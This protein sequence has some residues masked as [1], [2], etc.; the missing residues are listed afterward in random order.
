MDLEA[1]CFVS[2]CTVCTMVKM[3][4]KTR[5]RVYIALP[6]L[7]WLVCNVG[8]CFLTSGEVIPVVKLPCWWGK[9]LCGLNFIFALVTRQ[10]MQSIKLFNRR[11]NTSPQHSVR[12]MLLNWLKAL[13]FCFWGLDTFFL[14]GLQGLLMCENKIFIYNCLPNAVPQTTVLGLTGFS[15]DWG[16]HWVQN[17]GITDIPCFSWWCFVYRVVYFVHIHT[18]CTFAW[19]E[20]RAHG[21]ESEESSRSW[22]C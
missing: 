9:D 14:R 3:T 16:C 13:E 10:V 11:R 21:S 7:D 15:V 8:D 6:D 20:E 19:G 18:L 1:H 22:W 2:P 17:L 4:I 12:G 5:V